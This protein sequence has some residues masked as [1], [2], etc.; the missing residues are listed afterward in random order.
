MRARIAA[1]AERHD[2]LH[3]REEAMF[4]LRVENDP[5]RALLIAI[6]NWQVQKELA[7][8]RLVVQCARAAG[9]RAALEVVKQWVRHQGIVD[10]Q[11]TAGL[12]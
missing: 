9:D 7:D 2:R 4:V 11:L 6:E 10:A 12:L 8:A 1:A 5:A 3:A